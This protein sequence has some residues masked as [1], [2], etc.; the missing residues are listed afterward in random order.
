[1]HGRY[2]PFPARDHA[3]RSPARHCPCRPKGSEYGGPAQLPCCRPPSC[4][5]PPIGSGGL[6][7][8]LLVCLTM[9][10]PPHQFGK[11]TPPQLSVLGQAAAQKLGFLA[12]VLILTGI[13]DANE[14]LAI[15]PGKV[16][17]HRVGPRRHVGPRERR[18]L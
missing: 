18:S 14:I 13:D 8:C 7:R 2:T 5:T 9:E 17:T 3:G 1:N 6:A 4:G 16:D 11:K 12:K 15:A 10:L